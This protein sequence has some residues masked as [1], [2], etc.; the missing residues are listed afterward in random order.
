GRTVRSPEESADRLGCIGAAALARL[1]AAMA[2]NAY[3]RYLLSLLREPLVRWRQGRRRDFERHADDVARRAG[4][5]AQGVQRRAWVFLRKLERARLPRSGP[6]RD[7]RAGQP[8]AIAPQRAARPALP[9]R[10]RAGK[11]C[12]RLHGRSLRRCRRHSE[13]LADFRPLGRRHALGEESPDAVDSA[14]LRAWLS[15]AVRRG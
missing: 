11:A 1:G 2:K 12:T 14:G 15:R 7:V 9:D 6:R 4:D 10:A 3:G 8:F 5:R 13:K